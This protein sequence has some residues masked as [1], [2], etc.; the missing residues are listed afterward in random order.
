M[1]TA[2]IGHK[3]LGPMSDEEQELEVKRE[4]VPQQDNAEDCRVA[5]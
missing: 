2:D 5:M 4:S 3:A 1:R